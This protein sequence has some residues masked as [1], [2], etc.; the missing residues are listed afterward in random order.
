MNDYNINC[1]LLASKKAQ[2]GVIDMLITCGVDLGY[3]DK[4]GNNALHI[5][6]QGGHID[7]V[8][9]I[10]SY[11]WK[12]NKNK[13]KYVNQQQLNQQTLETTNAL[14]TQETVNATGV[15]VKESGVQQSMFSIDCMDFKH[16]TCLMKAVRKNYFD[17]VELLLNFGANPRFENCQGETALSMACV[18]ENPEICEKLIVAKASVNQ[19]D[20][21]GRT[22]ILRAANFNKSPAVIELLIKH[23]ARIDDADEDKNN[24]LHQSVRTGSAEII[25]SLIKLGADPYAF[26]VQGLV[27]HEM[28]ADEIKKLFQVCAVCKKPGQSAC[29][30]CGI[31][32]YCS[33]ECQKRDYSI[34][35]KLLCQFFNSRKDQNKWNDFQS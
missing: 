23:G 28:A 32:Y 35:S 34:H 27:P 11:Y 17:I 29:K 21:H 20:S 25:T 14:C 30:Y 18:E 22:P 12:S 3:M 7:I 2:V 6:C 4:N 8:R 31:V 9:K 15:T 10:L 16:T 1:L 19:A 24:V 13:K 26:N 5:A 33:V